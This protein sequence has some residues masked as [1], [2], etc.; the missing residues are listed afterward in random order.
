[1]LQKSCGNFEFSSNNCSA[2]K[3]YLSI[4]STGIEQTIFKKIDCS[5]KQFVKHLTIPELK[6]LSDISQ[7]ISLQK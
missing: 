6:I 7:A 1:M 4:L 2:K 3:A 5:S